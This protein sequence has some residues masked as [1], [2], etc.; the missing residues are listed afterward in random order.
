M[1]K[2]RID[3]A[4]N[5]KPNFKPPVSQRTLKITKRERE[6]PETPPDKQGAQ[7]PQRKK[8][9]WD[10]SDDDEFLESPQRTTSGKEAPMISKTESCNKDKFSGQARKTYTMFSSSDEEELT[11]SPP[12]SPKKF[13]STGKWERSRRGAGKRAVSP[14]L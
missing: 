4:S 5:K 11:K 13:L 7:S 8:P 2:Q 10:S 9:T 12:P 3:K 6:I 1:P 14:E